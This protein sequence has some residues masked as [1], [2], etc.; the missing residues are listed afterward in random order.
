VKK[1]GSQQKENDMNAL[2]R[3]AYRLRAMRMDLLRADR[4]DIDRAIRRLEG[5]Q[6][7]AITVRLSRQDAMAT[8]TR[9]PVPEFLRRGRA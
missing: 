6:A 2:R 4:A 5:K 8:R 7:G 9:P 3:L 1:P